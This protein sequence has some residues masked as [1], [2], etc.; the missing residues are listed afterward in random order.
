MKQDWKR[1]N[2][3]DHRK[4]LSLGKRVDFPANLYLEQRVNSTY[5]YTSWLP[6]IEDDPRT[7]KENKKTQEELTKKN[8]K[9]YGLGNPKN[10]NF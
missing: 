3:W 10:I 8:Q 5:I 2:I 9:K 4:E 7:R 1:L 6:N